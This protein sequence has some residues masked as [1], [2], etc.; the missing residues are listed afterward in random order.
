MQS[1]IN[2]AG[3]LTFNGCTCVVL[4][5]ACEVWN[6]PPTVIHEQCNLLCYSNFIH[7]HCWL[8]VNC[9]HFSRWV[10]GADLYQ[11]AQVSFCVRACNPFACSP[12]CILVRSGMTLLTTFMNCVRPKVLMLFIDAKI[13]FMDTGGWWVQTCINFTQG[14]LLD[15][16]LG[17]ACELGLE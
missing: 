10:V 3:M 1:C 5:G 15:Y 8:E 13:V 11:L 12:T 6:D 2:C 7:W 9:I 4:L 17:H 14:C 16:P